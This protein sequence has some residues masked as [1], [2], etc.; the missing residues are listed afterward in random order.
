MGADYIFQTDSDGQTSPDDFGVFWARRHGD[1]F[2]FGLRRRRGDGW[3]RF[4]ISKILRLVIRAATGVYVEDSNV[5]FRLMK[6]EKLA[7]Y[8]A[9]IPS[10]FYL[11]NALLP[12]VL[13]SGGEKIAWEP[14]TFDDR[15]GGSPS[16]SA[17]KFIKVGFMVWREFLSF[18]ISRRG[19][20]N[21]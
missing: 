1:D 2:I 3:A 11:A 21:A 6:A 19:G 15:R 4:V 13:L 16:V 18:A 10:R 14:I 12:V 7:K 17:L 8:L 20:R 9:E 5:P